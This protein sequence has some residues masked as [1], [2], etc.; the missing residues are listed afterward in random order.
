MARSYYSY[1]M[2]KFD[3][4]ILYK[5]LLILPPTIIV[6]AVCWVKFIGRILR[7]PS[8]GSPETISI[9]EAYLDAIINEELVSEEEEFEDLEEDFQR[10]SR[11]KN[12]LNAT[13]TKKTM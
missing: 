4:D 2:P 12:I 3:T 5:V 6:L 1:N 9:E 13:E 11:S 7:N 10:N 8:E